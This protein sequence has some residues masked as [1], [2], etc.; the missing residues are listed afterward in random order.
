MTRFGVQDAWLSYPLA[1]CYVASWTSNSKDSGV[2][3]SFIF[4]L[5]DMG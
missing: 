1:A 2:M 3:I 5:G 4:L